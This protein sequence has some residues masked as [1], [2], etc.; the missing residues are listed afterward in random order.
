[1]NTLARLVV[2]N[3]VIRRYIDLLNDSWVSI[4]FSLA[5]SA[6]NFH[7]MLMNIDFQKQRTCHQ[8]VENTSHGSGVQTSVY[9]IGIKSGNTVMV[10]T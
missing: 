6:E 8:D 5:K 9:R 7:K 10:N 4:C 1:M 3:R 2:I